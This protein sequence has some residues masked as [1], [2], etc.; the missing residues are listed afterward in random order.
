MNR[1]EVLLT[2]GAG[3]ATLAT[4]A[5][6]SSGSD[7]SGTG[8]GGTGDGTPTRAETGAGTGTG[9]PAV[10]ATPPPTASSAAAGTD[11]VARF[12]GFLESRGITVRDLRED[13]PIVT[14]E[15]A[16]G[17]TSYEAVSQDIGRV[18]GGFFRGVRDGWDA[19]R[20]EA[21]VTD[22]SGT[23]LATWYARAEWFREFQAGDISAEELSLRVL[24]TVERTGATGTTTAA[25]DTG[26]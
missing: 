7:R 17:S 10:S 23:A 19:T 1:R 13:G 25:A 2:G 14:L 24:R 9:T 21:T 22:P 3:L 8:D 6:C 4:L 26:R 11:H 15:Y 16:T 12:G 20:L 5:G 18:S